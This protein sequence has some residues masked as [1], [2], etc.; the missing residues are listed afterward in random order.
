M[1]TESE[2]P[3]AI[4]PYPQPRLRVL[5]NFSASDGR[6]PESVEVEVHDGSIEVTTDFIREVVSALA[7]V[8]GARDITVS[9][10]ATRPWVVHSTAEGATR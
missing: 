6:S 5:A 2:L 3:A 9:P 7:Q 8:P 10:T 1:S 4:A